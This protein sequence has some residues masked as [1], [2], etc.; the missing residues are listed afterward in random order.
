MIKYLIFIILLFLFL[1]YRKNK[2]NITE[3]FFQVQDEINSI[4][5]LIKYVNNK[6]NDNTLEKNL[7]HVYN[8]KKRQHDN[9][10][11][12]EKI[13]YILPNSDHTDINELELLY[14]N[15]YIRYIRKLSDGQKKME[16][17]NIN[18]KVIDFLY[19]NRKEKM[20]GEVKET[21]SNNNPN[22][23]AIIYNLIKNY[24]PTFT[25]NNKITNE[26][27]KEKY[28]L[29]YELSLQNEKIHNHIFIPFDVSFL[30][31]E[32]NNLKYFKD[33]DKIDDLKKFLEG[34]KSYYDDN[35]EE[36][37]D[38]MIFLNYDNYNFFMEVKNNVDFNKLLK[39]EDNYYNYRTDFLVFPSKFNYNYRNIILVEKEYN[40]LYK[41]EVEKLLKSR[42]LVESNFNLGKDY[43]RLQSK[44]VESETENID[45]Y[46]LEKDTENN[47]KIYNIKKHV[48]IKRIK[49]IFKE[50]KD[51]VLI[52]DGDLTESE[53][54]GKVKNISLDGNNEFYDLKEHYA[55]YLDTYHNTKRLKYSYVML[56]LI[57]NEIIL[58]N[59][60]SSTITYI[61][62]R[63][64]NLLE[65]YKKFIIS[66]YYSSLEIDVEK[67]KKN[68]I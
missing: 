5:D 32:N 8:L 13:N 63:T 34:I 68:L 44:N 28:I 15:N 29:K 9:I 66:E 42:T 19:K 31:N 64:D 22:D 4:D 37:V 47:N 46:I 35:S 67:K 51:R 56:Y 59:N 2:I 61:Y 14:S 12:E 10:I 30:P 16:N 55:F 53:D 38:D 7:I 65:F 45:G 21:D 18:N 25:I 1:V 39:A 11:R 57:F 41:S 27:P 36:N 58:E 23:L 49:E 33:L 43:I 40:D 6:A 17:L 52:Q 50:Y 3:P 24:N 48:D 54:K 62:N 20:L 60:G 26:I